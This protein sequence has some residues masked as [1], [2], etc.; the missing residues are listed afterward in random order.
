MD[1]NSP[2]VLQQTNIPPALLE[3]VET[4]PRLL[5][6]IARKMLAVQMDALHKR[7]R[8]PNTPIGQRQAFA[9]FLAKVGDAYPKANAM[10][11]APGSGFSVNIIMNGVPVSATKAPLVEDVT[12]ANDMIGNHAD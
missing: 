12:P 5:G 3:A 9:D 8:D 7:L 1:Q 11:T 10:V 2:A 6:A 4:D